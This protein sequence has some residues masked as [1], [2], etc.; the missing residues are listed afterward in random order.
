ME[1]MMVDSVQKAIETQLANI[2]IKTGKS[3]P[4]LYAF[5]Q[6]SGLSKHAEIRE[7]VKSEFN[8]GYGDANTLAGLYIK[9]LE[10]ATESSDSLADKVDEIYSGSKAPLLPL[11]E[12]VMKSIQKLGDFEISPKKTYLSLRRKKQFAMVGPGTKG[13]L[14]IGINMKDVPA[15]ERLVEMPP[16]GMC[17]YKVWI[18]ED[19]EIDQE[20]FDW[21]KVAYDSAG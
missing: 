6:R 14:E 16:G 8:L 15:K 10:P 12:A 18:T 21:I 17:Q 2:Q 13:R 11:H 4:D 9:S 19:K 3:L 20:L 5:I 1:E 7:L